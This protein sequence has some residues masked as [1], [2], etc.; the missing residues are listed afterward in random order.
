MPVLD[1]PGKSANVAPHV[2]GGAK[3]QGLAGNGGAKSSATRKRVL[4]FAALI[5][6][7]ASAGAVAWEL[8]PV[9]VLVSQVERDVPVQ[10]FGLGTVEARVTSKVGFKVSGVLVELGADVGD[11]VAKGAVLARLDDREQ[12]AQLARA[13][14]AIEQTEANLQRAKASVEKAKATSANAT[15][16]SERQQRL[17]QTNSTSVE[18]AETAKTT[19]DTALADLNLANSDVLVA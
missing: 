12:R 17:V 14:A 2:A 10:V 15:R 7:F 6:V 4:L 9:N 5:A 11:S 16:I 1:T 3:D 19:Q 13:K 18:A 8:F